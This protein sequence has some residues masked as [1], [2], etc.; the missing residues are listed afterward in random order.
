MKIMRRKYFS[1]LLILSVICV[2]LN[3][4]AQKFTSLVDALKNPNA[5]VELDLSSQ[6]LTE[7][8]D[9]MSKFVNLKVLNLSDNNFSNIPEV[10]FQLVSLEQLHAQGARTYFE[11]Y[12]KEFL[13][14]SISPAINKLSKLKVLNLSYNDIDKLPASFFELSE[15]SEL[16]LF[17]N[18][19]HNQT[20]LEIIAKLSRLTNLNL[21]ANDIL[22]L[23]DLFANLQSIKVLSLDNAYSE[24]VPVGEMMTEFP[25]ILLE[26][27][28]LEELSLTGQGFKDVPKSI[29]SLQN[30][31]MLWFNDTPISRLPESL[32]ELTKLE[33]LFVSFY[34]VA[35]DAPCSRPFYF[36]KSIC[37]LKNIKEIGAFGRT[38]HDSEVK[39]VKD[40]LGI[41]IR[42]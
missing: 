25:K 8:P 23:P 38:V 19:V 31:K 9:E 22:E 32:G 30:L 16:N 15:L 29:K 35:D 14:T 21:G 34:C 20:D 10:V 13:I 12:E 18:R 36:P 3:S 33:V 1:I 7:L 40:C 5:V 17:H 39:R 26:L 4:F 41:D 2:N 37:N 27:T 24:G 6:N 28:N 11:K 42:F